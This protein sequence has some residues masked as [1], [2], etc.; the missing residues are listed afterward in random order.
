MIGDKFFVET[1]LFDDLM[2]LIQKRV[3]GREYKKAILK[4]DIEGFEPYAFDQAKLLFE[5]LDFQVIFIEW[6]HLSAQRDLDPLVQNMIKL[7][8]DHQLIPYENE[9]KLDL[10]RWKSWPFD[11]IWKKENL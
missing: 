5:L 1:I 7:F 4:I 8:T 3:D 11:V 6:R 9:N 2:E 10:N